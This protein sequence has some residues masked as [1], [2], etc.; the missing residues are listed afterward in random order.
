[1]QQLAGLLERMKAARE[2]DQSLLYNAAVLALTEIADGD[3]HDFVN[4]P[5]VVAGQA[6]GYFKTGR[7][8]SA[9]ASHNQLL[10][11]VLEALGLPDQSFGDANLGQGSI[12]EL[13]T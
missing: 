13:R 6:G 2:G 11:S 3:R 10:V 7:T 1:M 9:S 12:P 5:I 8:I 4:M